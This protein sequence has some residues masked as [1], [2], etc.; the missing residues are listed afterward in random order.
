MNIS[1]SRKTSSAS[2]KV[3]LFSARENATCAKPGAVR[4]DFSGIPTTTPLP[5]GRSLD[6][7]YRYA[8]I[9]AFSSG[10]FPKTYAGIRRSQRPKY[11]PQEPLIAR[12]LQISNHTSNH[13]PLSLSRFRQPLLSHHT[14]IEAI[15]VIRGYKSKL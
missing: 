10:C 1:I 2:A 6:E 14:E 4:P 15:T 3:S 9:S 11:F 5:V 8:H 12:S 13:G 7:D